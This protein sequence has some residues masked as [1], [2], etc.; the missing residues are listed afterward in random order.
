MF[1][2]F[3]TV[4]GIELSIYIY[5]HVDDFLVTGSDTEMTA[6]FRTQVCARFPITELPYTPHLGI[7][8]KTRFM[9]ADPSKREIIHLDLKP[10]LE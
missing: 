5:I 9:H 1:Q 3:R 8:R 2:A 7:F 4:N 6:W 10:Y